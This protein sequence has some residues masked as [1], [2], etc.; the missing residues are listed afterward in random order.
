MNQSNWNIVT[1]KFQPFNETQDDMKYI[2]G[3]LEFRNWWCKNTY[4]LIIKSPF[5]YKWLQLSEIPQTSRN[6]ITKEI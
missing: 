6:K 4:D 1:V 3:K 5:K 2:C